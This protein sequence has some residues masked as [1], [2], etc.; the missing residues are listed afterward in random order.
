MG[1]HFFPK[2]YV[3]LIVARM[4]YVEMVLGVQVDWRTILGNQADNGPS[5]QP[6]KYVG[7]N[8]ST[9]PKTHLPLTII[10]QV[11]TRRP[12]VPPRFTPITPPFSFQLVSRISIVPKVTT[13]STSYTQ[14]LDL[15]MNDQI[16]EHPW[17]QNPPRSPLA[18]TTPWMHHIWM[19]WFKWHLIGI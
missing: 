2:N 18:Q 12:Q 1:N 9:P 17:E 8:R 11:L 14:D 13:Q 7:A 15:V 6:N 4:V 19:L 5:Y 3:P 10:P 16:V